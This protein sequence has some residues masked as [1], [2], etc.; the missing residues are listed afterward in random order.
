[1]PNDLFFQR[2]SYTER[3]LLSYSNRR[4]Y[5]VT[6]IY[7]WGGK[8]HFFLIFFPRRKNAF[9]PVENSH[10]GRL[11]TNFRRFQKQKAKKKKKKKKVL[12]LFNHFPTSLFTIFPSFL[13]N[14]STLFPFFSLPLFSRYVSKKFSP[15]EVSGGALCPLP[16]P[17]VCYA[18][19]P[20]Q[21]PGWHYHMSVDI[22]CL[23]IDPH[24]YADLTPNDPF[25]IQSA[26]NDPFF[27]TF[28]SNFTYNLQIFAHFARIL[29]DWTILRQFLT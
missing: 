1:M 22:K 8:V 13:L 21:V 23:S 11:K 4:M 18:T 5:G 2:K 16:P 6:G 19:G 15:S 28:V 9:F 26:P 29:R 24:F 12:T 7:F 3:P 17:P 25:F 27:S 10:F 14:F 20:I